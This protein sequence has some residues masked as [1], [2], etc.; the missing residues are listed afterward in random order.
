MT[1]STTAVPS[2]LPKGLVGSRCIANIKIAGEEF[3]CLLDTGSQVTT[4]PVS[5]YNQHFADQ[6]VKPLRDLL[7]VEGAAG[8]VVPYLG[9]VEMV[10]TFPREFLGADFDVSTLALVVPDDKAHQSQ[11]LIGMNTLEPLYNHH[12]GSDFSN[13]QPTANGYRAVLQ[14]LQIRH[15][16][17]QK[18]CDGVVRLAS[19]SPVLIPA[20]RTTVVDGSIPTN[21]LSPGQ[22]A[23]VEHSASPLP[24]GLCVKNYLIMLPSHSHKKIPVILSNESDQDV[25][26]PPLSTIA[27]LAVSPQI[28][29]HSMST[30]CSP[31]ES[32]RINLKLNFGESPIPPE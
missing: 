14:L 16:Q 7:Q 20:G 17:Q 30:S 21:M 26:I 8:Q 31:S 13:F 25:T 12:L 19:K 32:P 5:F 15:Q 1:Q 10:V 9:Y 4:I 29:S 6:P 11:V 18:G 27:E 22:W 24:G 28:L 2:Q 3:N 23:L